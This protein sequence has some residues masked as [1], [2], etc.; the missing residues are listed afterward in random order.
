MFEDQD[1]EKKIDP[2]LNMLVTMFVDFSKEVDEKNKMLLENVHGNI[3]ANVE[4]LNGVFKTLTEDLDEAPVKIKDLQLKAILKDH[5][6]LAATFQV[7][8]SRVV[9]RAREEIKAQNQPLVSSVSRLPGNS[10]N[11]TL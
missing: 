3:D 8:T 2:I 4:A 7:N 10:P 9:E 5:Q 1:Q 6:D 11:L